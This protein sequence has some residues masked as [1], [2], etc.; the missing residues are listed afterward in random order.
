MV[1][2]LDYTYTLEGDDLKIWFA[3]RGSPAYF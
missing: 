2:I 1:D 3:D